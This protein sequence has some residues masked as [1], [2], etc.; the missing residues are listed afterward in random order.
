MRQLSLLPTIF[1]LSGCL[2]LGGGGS[3]DD[4]YRNTKMPAATEVVGTLSLSGAAAG[5]TLAVGGQAA[6]AAD[7]GAL[8]A[9]ASSIGPQLEALTSEIRSLRRR[10]EA[11]EPAINRLVRVEQDMSDLISEMELLANDPV[12]FVAPAELFGFSQPAPA[13]TTPRSANSQLPVSSQGADAQNLPTPMPTP[14]PTPMTK[15]A[16]NVASAREANPGEQGTPVLSLG[17]DNSQTPRAVLKLPDA[18]S[19]VATRGPKNDGTPSDFVSR[20]PSQSSRP[21]P[22]DLQSPPVRSQSIP[23]G[24]IQSAATPR[25]GSIVPAIN[26]SDNVTSRI[27]DQTTA[28]RPN[29]AGQSGYP[30]GN[31]AG[32]PARLRIDDPAIRTAMAPPRQTRAQGQACGAFGIHMGSYLLPESIIFAR[33]FFRQRYAGVMLGLRYSVEDIDL[34]DG[35]GVFHRL[36]AGPIT[37]YDDATALCTNVESGGNYCMV[38]YFVPPECASAFY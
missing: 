2:G 37:N 13:G 11:M 30:A 26:G 19:Y 21:L 24:V 17:L 36:I 8:A 28:R 4:R 38:T 3:L 5:S 22:L 31:P 1:L 23:L 29:Q 35:R 25:T 18:D 16:G 12:P 33:E 34:R 14:T 6:A 10:F 27:P 7:G 32:D 20:P 15:Q 9:G